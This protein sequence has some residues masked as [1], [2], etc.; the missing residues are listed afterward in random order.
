LGQ[1][2]SGLLRYS[3]NTAH[4]GGKHQLIKSVN[5]L[6]QGDLLK[7]VQ[8]HMKF[9]MTG[10]EKDDLLI[11]VTT[12]TG[13]TV[14]LVLFYLIVCMLSLI[15]RGVCSLYLWFWLN[16]IILFSF[17]DH[18]DPNMI[19][20]QFFG[21]GGGGFSFGGGGGQGGGFPGGFSFQF[22]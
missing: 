15:Q 2:G 12:W 13:L 14:S 16:S 17:T 11:E 19:F 9:S 1:R 6:R 18:I 8:I 21:G 3:W 5:L 20:Q 10:Q 22:G 7:E 4:I